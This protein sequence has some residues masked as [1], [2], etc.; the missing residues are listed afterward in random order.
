MSVFWL[1]LNMFWCPLLLSSVVFS[2]LLGDGMPRRVTEGLSSSGKVVS[3]AAGEYFTLAATDE[4]ALIGWGDGGSGQLGRKVASGHSNAVP[5]D[6]GEKRG[7]RV[8]VIKPVGGYQHA[9]AIAEVV[10]GQK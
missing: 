8:R 3:V 10:D 4:G 6:V 1:N 5:I 2:L 7:E 9:I